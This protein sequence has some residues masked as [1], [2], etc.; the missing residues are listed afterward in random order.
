[1]LVPVC[2]ALLL[3]ACAELPRIVAPDAAPK[4]A[5]PQITE[6]TLRERARNQLALGAKQYEAGQYDAAQKNLTEALDHGLLSK[7]DQSRVRKL[8]A[9]IH[10]SSGRE[11]ACRDEFRKAFEINP[12][13]SL[14][15]AED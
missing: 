3:A 12:E 14:T 7:A 15:V 2:L 4:A 10:C 9:F 8:L 11:A 1:R 6:E 5:A 13:F